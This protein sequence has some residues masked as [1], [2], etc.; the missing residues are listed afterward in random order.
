[1]SNQPIVQWNYIIYFHIRSFFWT[2]FCIILVH[3]CKR[4]V[5][6]DGLWRRYDHIP[7]KKYYYIIERVYF[8]YRLLYI[9]VSKLSF[10][11]FLYTV[12]WWYKRDY[13]HASIIILFYFMFY[14]LTR[15]RNISLLYTTI[16]LAIRKKSIWIW[17]LPPPPPCPLFVAMPLCIAME[18]RHTYNF[19]CERVSFAIKFT[20]DFIM[21]YLFDNI[22]K[23]SLSA[24][25]I[26]FLQ[27]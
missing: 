12:L 18:E 17:T 16:M 9:F 1:M 11:L 4:F 13:R 8:I 25:Y 10:V 7:L 2:I 27:L 23:W 14:L 6:C 15:W 5:C 21:F 26:C 24:R 22:K 3:Q 19:K 20:L